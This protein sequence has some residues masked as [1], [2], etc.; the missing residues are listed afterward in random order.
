MNKEEPYRD[1]A[2]R[3][4]QRIQKINEKNEIVE[5]GDKLPPREQI[6]RQKK[7]KTKWKLKYP[8][9]SFL[10]LSFILL[11]V[12]IYSVISYSDGVKK[13]NG[14]EKN[15][16]GSVW[17]EPINFEK[18]KKDDESKVDKS[19]QLKEIKDDSTELITPEEK[20]EEPKVDDDQ[21]VT[22]NNV[23]SSPPPPA[24]NAAN[25]N[26][27]DSD[28]NSPQQEQKTN[29]Q[30]NTPPK[31][32]KII[33]HTVQP[34]ETLFKLANKYYYSTKGIDIIKK[35]NNLHSDQIQV[36]QVLKIPLNN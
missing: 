20:S 13:I 2:E 19:D 16:G 21:P 14:T 18:Q 3:L 25:V 36:G 15:S 31:Q 23:N 22:T 12:I 27:Q 10:V 6:H 30:T 35:A 29:N 9:I 8:V 11:P 1:Q 26:K 34:Q 24:S 4:K 32:D 28:K 7:K 33:Y 17:N 5:E